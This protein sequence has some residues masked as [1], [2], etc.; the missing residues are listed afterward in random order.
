MKRNT[1]SAPAPIPASRS[2]G[3]QL[4]SK[5]PLVRLAAEWGP[6]ELQSNAALLA[7]YAARLTGSHSSCWYRVPKQR[8]GGAAQ[9]LTLGARIGSAAVPNRLPAGHET[10]KFL[11]ECGGAAVQLSSSGPFPLL[12]LHDTLQSAAAVAVKARSGEEGLLIVG[13]RAPYAYNGEAIAIL[14][15]LGT[16]ARHASYRRTS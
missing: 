10:V 7:D 5:A 6:P 16:F 13:S 14:E 2:A 1:D 12:L 3:T 8:G 11:R 9:W 15:E 4:Q